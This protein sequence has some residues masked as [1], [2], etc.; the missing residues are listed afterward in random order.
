MSGKRRMAYNRP[1]R[2]RYFTEMTEAKA[3]AATA[4]LHAAVAA[5]RVRDAASL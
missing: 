5:A 3:A 4:A 1:V 2:G